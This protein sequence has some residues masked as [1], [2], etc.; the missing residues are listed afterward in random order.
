MASMSRN[1]RFTMPAS[2]GVGVG[3]GN[4]YIIVFVA[5]E[6]QSKQI[7]RESEIRLGGRVGRGFH[8][9]F[10]VLYVCVLF[11]EGG[12][13]GGVFKSCLPPRRGTSHS[14]LCLAFLP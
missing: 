6:R 13:G 4:V 5:D 11:F 3:G 9:F 12:C 7:E 14:S 10:L 2:V 8:F 1:T